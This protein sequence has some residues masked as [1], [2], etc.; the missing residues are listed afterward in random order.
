MDEL[1]DDAQWRVASE[2]ERD[3]QALPTYSS[4]V[5][6]NYPR[7]TTTSPASENTSDLLNKG[8]RATCSMT[9]RAVLNYLQ[10]YIPEVSRLELEALSSRT[11]LASPAL[12]A[13]T[14]REISTEGGM[15]T[16]SAVSPS[17]TTEGTASLLQVA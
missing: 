8:T 14:Y 1:I 16:R 11:G 15:H 13:I 2:G 3:L 4:T 17:P 6:P 9:P 7:T 5:P 12:P 10:P